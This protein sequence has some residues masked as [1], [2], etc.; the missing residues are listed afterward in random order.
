M[1]P[2]LVAPALARGRASAQRFA[3]RSYERHHHAPADEGRRGACCKWV[4]R[5]GSSLQHVP[6]G[7]DPNRR[8][9]RCGQQRKNECA[10]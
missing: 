6:A 8:Y 7:N 3:A 1:D 4:D 10:V 2:R 9:A 5:V